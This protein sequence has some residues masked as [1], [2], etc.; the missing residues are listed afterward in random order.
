MKKILIIAG[1]RPEA[2]KVAPVILELKKYPKRIAVKT[3]CTG[4]HRELLR[5]IFDLF[6]IEPDYN[7]ELMTQNQTLSEITAK[8]F[9][10]LNKVI[11]KESPDW[12]LAQGDTATVMVASVLSYYHRIKFGHIE[13]GLRT[14]DLYS[15]YPE[16]GN[17]IIADAVAYKL[18]A[19]TRQARAALIKSGA[20]KN[21][22]TVTGNTVIDAL[23][24]VSK[25]K[26]DYKNS[27]LG[28]YE[29]KKI[30]LI[31]AHR[32]ESFGLDFENMCGAIRDLAAK[33]KEMA[34]VYPVHLNPNVRK[35]VNSTLR[36][37]P[38][39]S[40]IEPLEYL[41]FV[42]VMKKSF[43]I[44]TDSGGVQEEAPYFDV[45]ALVMR[46]KTERNEGVKAGVSMVVGTGR[47]KIVAAA[48]VLIE[49][50]A[51]YKKMAQSKNPYGDGCASRY[52][53]REILEN[54]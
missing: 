29:G 39:I 1:T 23:K 16:E 53:V 22:I 27:I 48:S 3:C 15:P 47:K 52:I 6:G 34:F 41:D 10:E 5:G 38:N 37:V 17:R 19:P 28:Q 44:L 9:L 20:D 14:G 36:G 42:N 33:Y 24:I 32:R 25:I 18:W 31:T 45:P 8:M 2:I 43:L 35:I 11:E 13:A 7:L 26:Y 50:A 51:A 54:E 12:I 49:D 30:V 40:L 21:K 46:K 4:Q